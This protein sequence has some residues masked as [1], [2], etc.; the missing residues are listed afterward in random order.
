MLRYGMERY[1]TFLPVMPCLST[2]ISRRSVNRMLSRTSRN[3]SCTCS[4]CPNSR[5]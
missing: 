2:R 4:P 3:A 1:S 5:A